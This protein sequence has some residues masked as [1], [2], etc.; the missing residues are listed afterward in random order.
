MKVAELKNLLMDLEN[1]QEIFMGSDEELNT[2]YKEIKVW[3]L[4]RK[5]YVIIPV[6]GSETDL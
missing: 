3:P 6:N 5:D 2:L 4:D 1:D